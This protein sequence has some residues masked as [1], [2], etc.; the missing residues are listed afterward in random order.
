MA[1][2]VIPG[3]FFEMTAGMEAADQN[4]LLAALCQDQAGFSV[5]VP[6][7]L[8]FMFQ[9]F[10]KEIVK[11]LH[12]S[13]VRR[14]A[15]RKSGEARRTN[16]NGTNGEQTTNKNEQSTNKNEQKNG[17]ENPEKEKRTKKEKESIDQMETPAGMEENALPPK[18]P[19]NGAADAAR[20]SFTDFWAAY[21]RKQA[22]ENAW[23]AWAKL[24]PDGE[25]LRTIL[26]A[27]ERQKRTADW[28]KEGGRY[29]PL[30]A[31]WLN[32]K[33]WEDDVGVS[34]SQG[35]TVSAQAYG[36]RQYTEAELLAVGPDL[37]AEARAMRGGV[38][39]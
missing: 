14:D 34:S 29:I 4:A 12:I 39:P 10:K 30:A 20:A 25:L 32:G 23:K 26:I 18:S 28:I 37:M 38:G 15:G 6:A 8:L 27:L 5:A 16:K 36:Q 17:P 13:A 22:R 19:R 1:D 33:R 9:Y 7:D 31:S 3:D 2:Y 24:A 35:K 21:P 11:A